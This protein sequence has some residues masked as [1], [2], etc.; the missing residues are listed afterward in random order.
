MNQYQPTTPLVLVSALCLVL[1][2]ACTSMGSSTLPRDRFNYNE[3]LAESRNQQMLLNVVRLRYLDIPDFIAV[4]S[5]ITSYTYEGEVGVERTR[6][7]ENTDLVPE[8]FTG[9]ANLAYAERPTITYSPLAGEDF[10]RRLLKPIPVEV[11]FSLG[12]AGWPLDILLAITLQRMNDVE[13]MGFGQV[14]SPGDVDRDEQFAKE[15]INLQRF[16]RVLELLLI[17]A[18]E[19]AVEVQYRELN[20]TQLPH[21]NFARN[22]P[23]HITALVDELKQILNLDPEINTFR[24][25]ERMTGRDANEMTIQSRSLM[26]IMSFLSRGTEVPE[27]DVNAGRVVVI[28]PEVLETIRQRVPLHIQS[29]GAR[30]SDPYVAVRYRSTWFYIDHS[31]IRSKRTFATM[32]VLF[33]LAAPTGSAQAPMLT[34][35]TGGGR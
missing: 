11:I 1:L 22:K 33:N 5:V 23:P 3:A 19:G 4:S 20:D 2:N 8:T 9:R 30:P 34:L 13:N 24:V 16:Q 32:L 14:P 10:S 18:R 29:S 25:T 12:Q 7:D 26:S 35:P 15:A 31:D 27:R 21:L 6:T 17:L 28:P